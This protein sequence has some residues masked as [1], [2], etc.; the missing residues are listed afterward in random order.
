MTTLSRFYCTRC[1][2]S[3][4]NRVIDGVR[5][6]IVLQLNVGQI[7]DSG[8]PLGIVE[9]GVK[10]PAWIRELMSSHIPI[11]NINLCMV[12]VSEVFGTPLVEA[13]EDPMYSVEQAE[14]SIA[15]TR[16]T[17]ADPDID[18]VNRGTIIFARTFD[19]IQVGRGAK[20]APKLPPKR[21]MPKPVPPPPDAI[22]LNHSEQKIRK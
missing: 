1:G 14:E 16:A 22:D 8:R 21:P 5:V 20:K 6:P 2:I 17:V 18:E 13:T 11:A 19:A 3:I 7:P 12:C 10:L 4:Y 15:V 9:P